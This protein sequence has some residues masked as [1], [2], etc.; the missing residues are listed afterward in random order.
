VTI[1]QALAQA[2][3]ILKNAGIVGAERDAR[4]LLSAATG[5]ARDQ[6]TLLLRKDCGDDLVFW[7]MVERRA[8]K[9]PISHI[10]GGR[11]F[12]GR[13]F[14]V[15]PEVLDPRPET[16][17]LISEALAKPY[18]KVLDLGTGS[19]C[20]LVTLLAEQPDARGVGTDVSEKAVLIA[21]E[22]AAQH[23][24]ADRIIL[25]LSHW[26]DDVGGRYDLIVSNPPYIALDEM[27][28]LLLD[29][30]FEPRI[31]L[32]DEADGLSAY[33]EIIAGAARH[34]IPNGRVLVE[35]GPSQADEV[36]RMFQNAGFRKIAVTKDFDNRDRVISATWPKQ[37]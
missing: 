22:N 18:R 37:S 36:C 28:G 23:G 20:I 16:E 21:G 32:T 10:V 6:I 29:V 1:A 3:T 19:G 27:S 9:E 25:P 13:W 11:D 26:W 7:E 8:N 5:I 30:H 14:K 2:V 33:L 12:Y 31:A 35:I 4:W 34:L 17:F 24:V 15:T